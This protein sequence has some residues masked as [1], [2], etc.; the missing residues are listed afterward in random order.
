MN[1]HSKVAVNA[2]KLHMKITKILLF[3]GKLVFK[4]WLVNKLFGMGTK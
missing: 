1:Y 2:P 4:G 3:L